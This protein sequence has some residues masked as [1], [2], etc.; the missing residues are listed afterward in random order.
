MAH[1]AGGGTLR[2]SHANPRSDGWPADDGPDSSR[3]KGL[4]AEADAVVVCRIAWSE[5]HAAVARHARAAPADQAALELA[6]ANLVGTGP[7]MS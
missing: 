2:A 1:G 3:A 4:V 5:F 6:K 7:I